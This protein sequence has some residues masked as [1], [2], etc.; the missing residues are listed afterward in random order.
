MADDLVRVLCHPHVDRA[1]SASRL[2]SHLT[3]TETARKQL[4]L[5]EMLTAEFDIQNLEEFARAFSMTEPEIKEL[6]QAR[7]LI[8][9]EVYRI[10]IQKSLL[11]PEYLLYALNH[12][13]N[14]GQVSKLSKLE[15]VREEC[16]AIQSQQPYLSFEE[17]QQAGLEPAM[18][19]Y[20]PVQSHPLILS[21]LCDVPRSV[22]HKW[23]EIGLAM[24][25]T[26]YRIRPIEI[27]A[28]DDSFEAIALVF[29]SLSQFDPC[30]ETGHLNE[31]LQFLGL[32]ENEIPEALRCTPQKPIREVCQTAVI[33][34]SLISL[35]ELISEKI[36]EFGQHLGVSSAVVAG[37]IRWYE[38]LNCRERAVY[39][40][41]KTYLQGGSITNEKAFNAL[42]KAVLMCTASES[43]DQ[44][45]TIH[46]AIQAVL[47]TP[48]H[49]V[50]PITLDLIEDPVYL[51]NDQVKKAFERS[52]LERW[53]GAN[54]TNPLT[55]RPVT[56]AEVTAFPALKVKI[57]QW[58]VEQANIHI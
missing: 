35:T 16:P 42:N 5:P 32:P 8:P 43:V 44:K 45:E 47:A 33:N 28:R 24:G 57:N 26:L 49:F 13:G 20:Q 34:R 55:R 6:Q 39:P 14:D 12:S 2:V 48:D 54:E 11:Y 10:L 41:I 1:K 30:L 31:V 7:S 25:L 29:E 4:T 56:M 40:I 22:V 18:M 58:K 17:K 19:E 21:D 50:C 23:Q 27:Q 51:T 3:G 53:I 15:N 37:H 9:L 38:R 46:T 36:S 52:A